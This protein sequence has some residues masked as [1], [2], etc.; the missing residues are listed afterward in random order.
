MAVIA[1]SA[2][3]VAIQTGFLSFARNDGEVER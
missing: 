2:S 1:R 3:D